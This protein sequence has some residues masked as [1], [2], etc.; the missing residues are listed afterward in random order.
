MQQDVRPEANATTPRE[1]QKALAQYREPDHTRSTLELVITGA[2]F[3]VLWVIAWWALSISYW[4]SLA[5]SVPAGA[6]LMRLFL[7][8]HDCGHNAF[9]RRKSVNDW[10][11][12]ILGVLTLT[13]YDY[14]RRS[15]AIHHATSG[16][17]DRRGI[18]D[19]DILTVREYRALPRSRRVLY[20]LYRH[21]LVLFLLGPAYQFLLRNRLPLGIADSD[22]GYWISTMGTNV[23]IAVAA[24]IMIYA[25]GLAPFLMIQLPITLIA[26]SIGVWLF[27]V[28]HQFEHTL[29]D[30]DDHWQLPDAALYGS[31]HYDL[32]GVLRW[33]T[34]NIGVHHVH[35]L[36]SRIPF[37]RLPQVLRDFPELTEVKRLTLIESFACMKLRLWDE[38][39]RRLVSFS[40]ARAL[41]V[42]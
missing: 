1:F 6:F 19:I 5:I 3:V 26:S 38:G 21:P 33:I 22:R 14:W 24:S 12:R 2:S 7:I 18:G 10:V 39:Q 36:S 29:W 42:E 37:Y 32:P 27:Y 30:E 35:H 8:Q 9:F 11:G 34:A 17:L 4:L 23:S 41:S 15:H 40:E 16:N 13:P 20:R 28:Q 25:V 31:S